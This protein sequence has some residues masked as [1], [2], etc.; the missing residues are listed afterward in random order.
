[1]ENNKSPGSDGLP[2]EFY[3]LF[4]QDVNIYLVN[5]LNSAYRK[6]GFIDISASWI[7]NFAP[8]EK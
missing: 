1:M 2:A 4:W 3:K 6:G 5:A 8:V 7:N